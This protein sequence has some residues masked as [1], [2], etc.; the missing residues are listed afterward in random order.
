MGVCSCQRR[1]PGCAREGGERTCS[2]DR[3]CR[4]VPRG[5]HAVA[6]FF[7][8]VELELRPPAELLA[9]IGL[10]DACKQAMA[11]EPTASSKLHLEVSAELTRMGIAHNNELCLPKLSYHVDIAILPNHQHSRGGGA[12]I[13]QGGCSREGGGARCDGHIRRA[14]DRGRRSVAL[15]RCAAPAPCDRADTAAPRARGLC[16]CRGAVLGMESSQGPH[17]KGSVPRRAA[18]LAR[19][20]CVEQSSSRRMTTLR[21]GRGAL[22]QIDVYII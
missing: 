2:S 12:S 4:L 15:R 11:D 9:P 13:R 22:I 5:T 16:R 14:R 18:L 8:S 3:V 17:T 6:Q 1:H 7:L 19:A 20:A 21:A 10:R